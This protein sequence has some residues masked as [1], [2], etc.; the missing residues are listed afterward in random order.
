MLAGTS[1]FGDPPLQNGTYSRAISVVV[2]DANGNP[3]NPNTKINFFLVDAPITGYPANPGAFFIAGDDGNPVEGQYQFNAPGGDFQSK[4]V[5]VF[6]RLVLD[7]R[8]TL[9]TYPG[10][11]LSHR[12]VAGAGCAER[13]QPNRPADGPAV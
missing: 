10:Q 3:T 8:A 2:S 4:G 6:N 5:R 13:D 11:P 7:G 9:S 1:R 12:R